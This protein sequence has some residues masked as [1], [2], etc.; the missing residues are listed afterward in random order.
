MSEISRYKNLCAQIQGILSTNDW[1]QTDLAK[2]IDTRQPV[3]SAWLSGEAFPGERLR[4][5]LAKLRGLSLDQ[6]D[7]VIDGQPIEQRDLPLTAEQTM[8]L[9]VKLPKTELLNLISLIARQ[10]AG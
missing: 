7:A 5:E 2:H 10:L 1:T 4:R 3:V 9:L 8:P 6:F